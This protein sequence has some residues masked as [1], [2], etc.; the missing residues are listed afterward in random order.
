MSYIKQR[1]GILIR[2]ML[3]PDNFHFNNC[4][5]KL[6]VLPAHPLNTLE[7]V[8]L[9]VVFRL[10]RLEPLLE[11]VLVVGVPASPHRDRGGLTELT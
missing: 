9:E 1:I 8:V 3:G 6:I 11:Q 5:I 4:R 7:V 2:E 10:S